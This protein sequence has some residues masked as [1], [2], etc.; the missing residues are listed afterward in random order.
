V[1]RIVDIATDG[2]HLSVYRGFLIVE[3]E[4]NEVGRV[5]LDDIHAV[6]VHAHGVT[7]T[8]NLVTQLAARGAP[9]V[10]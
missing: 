8:G 2:R 3:E 4:G 9:I 1:D 7:W 10:F 5:A 6:I